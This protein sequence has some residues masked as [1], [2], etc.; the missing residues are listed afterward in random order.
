MEINDAVLLVLMFIVFGVPALAI[1]ARLVI[2]PVIE[3][4]LRLR[5]SYGSSGAQASDPRIT[6][7]EAQV[8]R[9]AIEVQRLTESEAF[10]RELLQAPPEKVLP[11]SR[12]TWPEQP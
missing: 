8:S 5:E 4:I 11:E 7:L 6:A 10:N 3:A 1:A 12:R 9:L 2:R